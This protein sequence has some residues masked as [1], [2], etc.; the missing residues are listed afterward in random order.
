VNKLTNLEFLLVSNNFDTLT[1]VTEG[2]KQFGASFGFVPA[3]DSAQRYIERRKLDAIFVDLEVPGALE[4]IQSIRQGSSNRLAVIFACVSDGKE[5]APTLVPGANFLL[6]KP[7]TAASVAAHTNAAREMMTRERR[8]Y[9]RHPLNLSVSL[10]TAEGELWARM[11]N[12]GEGGMALHVVK[13]L[14]YASPVEF[15]FELPLGQPICGKGV[16][17]WANSEGLI[18]VKFQLIRGNDQEAL[19]DWLANRQRI[20]CDPPI[21]TA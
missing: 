4:L 19:Q 5:S 9:F 13:R 2:L 20:S 11:T 10:K 21:I 6:E 18:G 17:A 14:T 1:A 3:S 8:R 15:A 7:I 16:V 12:L